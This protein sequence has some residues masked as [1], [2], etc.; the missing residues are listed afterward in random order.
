[1]A[2]DGVN[3]NK[4]SIQN[5]V[6]S[7]GNVTFR[8]AV[9]IL[10]HVSAIYCLFGAENVDNDAP[11]V[12]EIRENLAIAILVSMGAMAIGGWFASENDDDSSLEANPPQF[13]PALD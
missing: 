12:E 6:Q 10:T 5:A 7:A 8:T 11:F 1:M 2:I 4:T 9:F 3:N 13:Q